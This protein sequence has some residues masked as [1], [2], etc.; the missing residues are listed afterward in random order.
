M[1]FPGYITLFKDSEGFIH[2]YFFPGID[3]NETFYYKDLDL[4]KCNVKYSETI[5]DDSS[6]EYIF[7]NKNII[8]IV[9]KLID[10]LGNLHVKELTI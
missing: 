10:N 6:K 7:E 4:S 9:C 2:L 3:D 1:I 5:N 8:K